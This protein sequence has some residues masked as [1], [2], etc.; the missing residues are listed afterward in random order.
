MSNVVVSPHVCALGGVC[1]LKPM[2]LFPSLCDAMLTW[3]YDAPDSELD[4]QM[5]THVARAL[6]EFG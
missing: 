2:P 1:V 4:V 6:A 3:K 5:I